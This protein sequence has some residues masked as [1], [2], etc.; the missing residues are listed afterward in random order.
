[1]AFH[2]YYWDHPLKNGSRE[3]NYFEWNA[4]SRKEAAKHI[5]TDTRKQPKPE[6][7]VDLDP[8][9]RV[10]SPPGGILIFSGAQLHSTVPNTTNK[11]RFS[12]DFRTVNLSDVKN[13]VGAPNI[14]SECTGTTLRDYLR[15]TDLE[16]I[17]EKW[18]REY[19]PMLLIRIRK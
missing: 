1:M 4:K 17:P 18:V 5:K 10:V 12:I 2:P 11:T 19:I 6:E 8:Q 14:D 3:Y 9:I 15:C 7:D 13:K 16:K